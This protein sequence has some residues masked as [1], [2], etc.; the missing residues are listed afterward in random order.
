MF[1][2][3]KD[4]DGC[5]VEKMGCEGCYYSDDERDSKAIKQAKKIIDLYEHG[6][7]LY[8][9]DETCQLLR[10]LVDIIERRDKRISELMHIESAHKKIN[11]ELRDYINKLEKS[12]VRKKKEIVNLYDGAKL[13]PE[14]AYTVDVLNEIISEVKTNKHIYKINILI[15]GDVIESFKSYDIYEVLRWF[16]EKWEDKYERNACGYEVYEDDKELTSQDLYYVGFFG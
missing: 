1:C 9:T 8:F 16:K 6:W 11:G 15:L 4:R 5:R 7:P 14:A 13:D 3:D 2:N 10:A 12:V